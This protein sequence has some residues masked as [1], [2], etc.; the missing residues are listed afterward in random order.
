MSC[1]QISNRPESD[2]N[3][4]KRKF[5]WTWWVSDHVSRTGVRGHRPVRSI[6]VW[7]IRRGKYM[8]CLL[9]VTKVLSNSNDRRVRMS[10]ILSS[11]S[12]LIPLRLNINIITWA[13]LRVP[14][15]LVTWWQLTERLW[16]SAPSSH[17]FSFS[18]W[19]HFAHCY[20]PGLPP[21]TDQRLL[22][23]SRNRWCL[24]SGHSAL[25]RTWVS[26]VQRQLATTRTH[27]QSLLIFIETEDRS[28]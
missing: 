23:W 21:A 2:R 18:H 13:H 10:I 28:S 6:V 7:E 15:G 24:V 16:L 3:R 25:H 5:L 27:S 11:C 1:L 17:Y 26:R 20:P 22:R 12:A 9:K 8:Q 19:S 4:E 14:P